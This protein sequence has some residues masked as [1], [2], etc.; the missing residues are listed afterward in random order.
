MGPVLTVDSLLSPLGFRVAFS[1]VLLI[2][3][4]LINLH[5][6]HLQQAHG[7]YEHTTHSLFQC[8]TP[9]CQSLIKLHQH[10]AHE[11]YQHTTHSFNSIL[12]VFKKT[13]SRNT[14]K[15]LNLVKMYNLSMTTHTFKFRARGSSDNLSIHDLYGDEM[16]R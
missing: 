14:L 7:P 3:Y 4:G 16:N 15:Q 9:F 5:Q 8:T 13:W 12:S 11:P 6:H 2:K 10:P 1:Q